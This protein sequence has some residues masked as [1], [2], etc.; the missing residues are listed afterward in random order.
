MTHDAQAL[1]DSRVAFIQARWHSDI[2]DQARLGFVEDLVL[3]P[4]RKGFTLP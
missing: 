3:V 1:I 2:V 4:L